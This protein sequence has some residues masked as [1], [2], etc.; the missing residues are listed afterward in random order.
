M[1]PIITF[2]IQIQKL[3]SKIQASAKLASFNMPLPGAGC[4]SIWQDDIIYL[5]VQAKKIAESVGSFVDRKT[6]KGV[7]GFNEK[8]VEVCILKLGKDDFNYKGRLLKRHASKK[9]KNTLWKH[10]RDIKYLQKER[11]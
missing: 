5:G 11:H 10:F 3:N 6:E 9:L 7:P 1:Y 4:K 2:D 8:Q